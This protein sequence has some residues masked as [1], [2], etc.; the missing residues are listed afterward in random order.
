MYNL[1]VESVEVYEARQAWKGRREEK[2]RRRR[3][4]RRLFVFQIPL[5]SISNALLPWP[6]SGRSFRNVPSAL[7]NNNSGPRDMLRV[8]AHLPS[9][10]HNQRFTRYRYSNTDACQ[11]SFQ[12]CGL[13]AMQPR[14]SQRRHVRTIGSE[15]TLIPFSGPRGSH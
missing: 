9:A 5:R 13:D 15:Q 4:R 11:I 1:R 10:Y 3:R 6:D 12:P 7:R 14:P 8:P 2:R